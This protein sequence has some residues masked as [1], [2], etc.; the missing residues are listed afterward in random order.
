MSTKR[1]ATDSAGTPSK[2]IRKVLTL[3][4]KVKVIKAVNTGLSN[5]K[6]AAKFGCGH[7]QVANILLNKTTILEAYTNG[8]K[9]ETQISTIP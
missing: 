5:V 1:K 4:E 6:I 7:T 9:A 3:A 8:A 2:C